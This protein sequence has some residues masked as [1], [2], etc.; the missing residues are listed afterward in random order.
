[1]A[2]QNIRDQRSLC[3]WL[4]RQY[5][6]PEKDKEKIWY[7]DTVTESNVL[8]YISDRQ[9]QFPLTPTEVADMWRNMKSLKSSMAQ[10]SD[11][12]Y[13]QIPDDEDKQEKGKYQTGDVSLKEIGEK[14]GGL[15]PTMVN[16]LANSAQE[17]MNKL[18]QESLEDIDDE[19]LEQVIGTIYQARFDAAEEFVSELHKTADVDTFLKQL[20]KKQYLTTN[21]AKTLS[22]TERN[23]LQILMEKDF[24][25]IQAILLQ[26]IEE[27]DNL[28]TTFQAM[29]CKKIFPP[30]KR[31]R[32][33]KNQ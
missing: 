12:E 21:E 8:D 26:D 20:M 2:F 24:N 1:M 7:S 31:G 23:A 16:K 29:I 19:N 27:T 32:P 22:Q 28:I 9:N 5:F 15:T 14:L 4:M 18:L 6:N 13:S 30:G 33:R 17:K 3:A 11:Y 10:I 25:T